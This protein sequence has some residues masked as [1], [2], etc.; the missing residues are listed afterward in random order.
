MHE[1]DRYRGG[2]NKEKIVEEFKREYY[3]SEGAPKPSIKVLSTS[4][5]AVAP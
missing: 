4:P 5:Q 1:G 3:V 2:A